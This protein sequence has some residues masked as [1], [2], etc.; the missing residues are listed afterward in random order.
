MIYLT[1]DCG[2]QYGVRIAEQ[3]GPSVNQ[4]TFCLSIRLSTSPTTSPPRATNPENAAESI[5]KEMIQALYTPVIQFT[6]DLLRRAITLHKLDFELRAH[7]TG[8]AS[9][10]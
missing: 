3:R 4:P 10:W 6:R 1:A 5:A 8:L 9:W 2:S 7:T